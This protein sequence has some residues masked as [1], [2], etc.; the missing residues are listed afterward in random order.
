M[1]RYISSK[2]GCVRATYGKGEIKQEL[3]KGKDYLQLQKVH[4]T[5]CFYPEINEIMEKISRVINYYVACPVKYQLHSVTAK[6]IKDAE[7]FVYLI[8]VVDY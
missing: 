1:Q 2:I 3:D 8:S 6:F 4:T 5:P 7:G